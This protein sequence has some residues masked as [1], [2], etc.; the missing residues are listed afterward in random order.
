MA[1]QKERDANQDARLT[2]FIKRVNEELNEIR[3]LASHP[4]PRG[5][6]GPQGPA[7]PQ[8]PP[9]PQGPRG[10]KGEPGGTTPPVEEPE[11][12]KEPEKPPVEEP[13]TGSVIEGYKMSSK[14]EMNLQ[15]IPERVTFPEPGICRF[16]VRAGDV[17]PVTP[18]ADPQ[19]AEMIGRK[20]YKEG[21]TI[22]IHQRFRRAKDDS[23]KFSWLIVGQLH[24]NGYSGAPA[25]GNL[26]QPDYSWAV[27]NSI[28]FVKMPNKLEPG[29]WQDLL[30]RIKFSQG[31]SGEVEAFLN[32][33][34]KPVGTYHG[35][36]MKAPTVYMKCGTLRASSPPSTGTSAF[37]YDVFCSATTKAAA[38]AFK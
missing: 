8:G 30:Y 35:Q 14:S 29:V 26:V 34:T 5:E 32:D 11:K 36:T 20:D 6:Q 18:T 37:E 33:F 2:A 27:G 21:E 17:N 16:E 10:E 13:V 28:R 1:T 25:G 4:G 12:E 7:G 24:E 3:E 31:G 22:W 38:L 23:A 19:R 15:A 9:G